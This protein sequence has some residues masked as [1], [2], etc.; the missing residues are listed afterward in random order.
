MLAALLEEVK[1]T[2]NAPLRAD[3]TSGPALSLDGDEPASNGVG[4]AI[5]HGDLERGENSEQTRDQSR[6]QSRNSDRE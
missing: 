2:R 4:D 3:G 6:D 5:H 1:R